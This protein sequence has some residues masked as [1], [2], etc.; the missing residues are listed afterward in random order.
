MDTNKDVFESQPINMLLPPNIANN[1]LESLKPAIEFLRVNREQIHLISELFKFIDISVAT[2]KTIYEKTEKY[3]VNQFVLSQLEIVEIRGTRVIDYK[4]N[5]PNCNGL[6]PNTSIVNNTY[7]V[8]NNV[9]NNVTDDTTNN[10]TNYV[11]DMFFGELFSFC[12]QSVFQ[13][14]SSSIISLVIYSLFN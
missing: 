14:I 6:A 1:I 3:K 7:N 2:K 12:C 9:T 11:K 4:P 10:A 13:I 5:I 8:T